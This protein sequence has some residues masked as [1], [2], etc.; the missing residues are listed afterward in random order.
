ME[1]STGKGGEGLTDADAL[2]HHFNRGFRGPAYVRE[3]NNGNRSRQD[4]GQADRHCT[5]VSLER[6]AKEQSNIPSVTI[7]SVPSAPMKSLVVSNPAEDFLDLRRVLMT[8]P[9]GRTTVCG[10]QTLVE[11]LEW[12]YVLR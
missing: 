10:D 6:Y 12:G 8:S 1:R 4:R 2:V 5:F 7:P 11:A 3:L 9:E